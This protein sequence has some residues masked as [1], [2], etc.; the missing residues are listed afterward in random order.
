M[1]H[2]KRK[3][4]IAVFARENSVDLG[5]GFREFVRFSKTSPPSLDVEIATVISNAKRNIIRMQADELGIGKLFHCIEHPFDLSYKDLVSKYD[6][7]YAVFLDWPHLKTGLDPARV[8]RIHPGP[9]PLTASYQG[10]EIHFKVW[11]ALDA[12]LISQSAMTILFGDSNLVI[13][14]LPILLSKYI[15]GS[16][17]EIASRVTTLG[18]HWAA[19]ITSQV[20]N[21]YI[22]LHDEEVRYAD[23]NPKRLFF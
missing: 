16:P 7:E 8:I 19:W 2:N 11:R 5:C 13:S 18:I 17:A 12:D 10:M 14:Q 20:C 1:S 3:P 23:H 21:H 22:W 15:N 9:I 6:A 4:R